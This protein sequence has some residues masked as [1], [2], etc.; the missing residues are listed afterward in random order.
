MQGSL[1]CAVTWFCETGDEPAVSKNAI[2]S[3]VFDTGAYIGVI[4]AT[5]QKLWQLKLGADVQS[6]NGE[7]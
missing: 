2:G 6:A 7:Y 1:T 5:L 4:E 3:I